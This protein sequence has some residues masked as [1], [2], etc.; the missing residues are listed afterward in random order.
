MKTITIKQASQR[1]GKAQDTIRA[2]IKR[3]NIKTTYDGKGRVLI[4]L[5]DL[6]NAYPPKLAEPTSK[7][8][9]DA[10]AELI[11]TLRQAN[12]TQAELIQTLLANNEKLQA[13]LTN[14]LSQQQ[15]LS[16]FLLKAN[17]QSTAEPTEQAEQTSQAEP[18]EQ[19]KPKRGFWHRH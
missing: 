3:E 10:T 17:N 6:E 12:R 9:T 7:D 11:N 1:T 13:D 8:R 15:T 2:W 19:P 14:L 16:G 18:A 5:D 4:N